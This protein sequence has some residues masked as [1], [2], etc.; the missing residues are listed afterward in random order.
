MY[1]IFIN[2][3]AGSGKDTAGK[4]IELCTYDV[5]QGGIAPMVHLMKFAAP[6]KRAVHALLGIE[7]ATID[8]YEGPAKEEQH[9]EFFGVTPRQ[10]YIAMSE[11][12]AKPLWGQDFF[13][14]VAM[15]AA[16]RHPHSMVVFTDSG[17]AREAMPLIAQVGTKR[18]LLIRLHRDGKTFEGDI[19]SYI[20]LDGVQTVDIENNGT[21]EDLKTALKMAVRKAFSIW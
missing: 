14:L 3:P 17:F 2:G 18:C 5:P 9:A 15:R 11:K 19:R 16:L 12:L 7:N 6:L 10:A 1:V 4:L 21:T 13:G 20:D 8:A